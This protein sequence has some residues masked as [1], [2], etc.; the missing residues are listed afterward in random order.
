MPGVFPLLPGHEIVGRVSEVGAEAGR[1]S[2]GDIVAIS[3]TVDSCRECEPCR[4]EME[5]YY[6]AYPTPTFD[7]VD[8]V[9][10]SRTR[11]GYS[12]SYV[13]EVALHKNRYQGRVP[14][15][16]TKLPVNRSSSFVATLTIVSDASSAVLY[17]W[18]LVK[19][20]LTYPGFTLLMR[21]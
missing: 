18:P 3:V 12:D 5:T 19:S 8:R 17:P 2:P 7:G 14:S 4:R 11:G 9:D 13:G 20:V 6:L 10:G 1:F 21:M 16:P 15:S